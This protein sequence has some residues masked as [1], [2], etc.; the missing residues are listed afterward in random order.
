VRELV[1][2]WRLQYNFTRY[3]A[4]SNLYGG[5]FL[6][7]RSMDSLATRIGANESWFAA[8]FRNNA[9]RTENPD[10]D[11]PAPEAPSSAAGKGAATSEDGTCRR[12]HECAVA[13]VDYDDYRMC[14][15][16]ARAL[17]VNGAMA[18]VVDVAAVAL[19][20]VLAVLIGDQ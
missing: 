2:S 16:Q 19:T 13:N 8:Y 4:G 1:A 20:L 15:T 10:V 17:S 3:Y 5:E 14:S 18:S 11:C 9:V 6:T 7:A 12:G